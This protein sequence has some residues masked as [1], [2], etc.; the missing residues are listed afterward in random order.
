MSSIESQHAAPL[1]HHKKLVDKKAFDVDI[2]Q[3]F[4]KHR[5]RVQIV[6]YAGI[7]EEEVGR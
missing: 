6:N 5:V 4:G 1:K 3:K 7:C 2:L